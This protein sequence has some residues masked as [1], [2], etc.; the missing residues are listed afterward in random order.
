M[1]D[2]NEKLAQNS[3]YILPE[4]YKKIIKKNIVYDYLIKI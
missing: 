3:D 4:G 2:L 1:K